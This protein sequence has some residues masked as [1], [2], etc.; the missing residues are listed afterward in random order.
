MINDISYYHIII[1]EMTVFSKLPIMLSDLEDVDIRYENGCIYI[2]KHKT[3]DTKEYYIGSTRDFKHRCRIHK[4]NCNNE[5]I[6]EYNLK[7]YKYIRDN[8]GWDQWEIVKLYDYPCKNKYE[9]EQEERRAIEAYKSTLNRIIPTRT[10]KEY[11]REYHQKNRENILEK[12]RQ[13]RENNKEKL[14]DINK[15]YRENNKEKIADKSR[16]YRENNKEKLT[17]RFKQYRE[18][19]KEEINAKQRVKINCDNCNRLVSKGVLAR[20]KRTNYCMNHK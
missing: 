1:N 20:H 10:K 6:R 11:L 14:T 12:Q 3:D 7:V 4:S 18:N 8:G 16:R 13:Y 15:Q 5:N 17:E 19:N 2:L 9:L